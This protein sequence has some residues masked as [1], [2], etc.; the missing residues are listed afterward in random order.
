MPP[1]GVKVVKEQILDTK[2]IHEIQVV[3]TGLWG[4][5]Y[6]V[7]SDSQSDADLQDL[8]VCDT[9]GSL[10]STEHQFYMSVLNYCLAESQVTCISEEFPKI[11]G[12]LAQRLLGNSPINA[13]NFLVGKLGLLMATIISCLLYVLVKLNYSSAGI[14]AKH[15]PWTI[16]LAIFLCFLSGRAPNLKTLYASLYPT[17]PYSLRCSATTK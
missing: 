9:R 7:K 10:G 11:C 8:Y 6:L 1:I 16:F 14:Y 15:L 5:A 12:Y 4:E 2:K 3:T 13:S 17:K